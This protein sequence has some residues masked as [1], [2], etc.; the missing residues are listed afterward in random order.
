MAQSSK[1][2]DINQQG[3]APRAFKRFVAIQSIGSY[4]DLPSSV[5]RLPIIRLWYGAASHRMMPTA[6]RMAS[7]RSIS[8]G[9]TSQ[10]MRPLVS[11][12]SF[13]DGS[14]YRTSRVREIP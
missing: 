2:V 9:R 10:S 7:Q 12:L 14:D 3:P 4:Q 1:R 6:R 5:S 8:I 13:E 11:R